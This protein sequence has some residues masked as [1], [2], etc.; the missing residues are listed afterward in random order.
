MLNKFSGKWLALDG[1]DAVGKSTQVRLVQK[2]LLDAG[3]DSL[4][5]PEFSD[6][7]VGQTIQS[8][9]ERQRFYALH[10]TKS[11]PYADTYALL[12]DMAF[13][14]ES[15]GHQ[16]LQ[17]GGVVL[18]DRGLLSLIGYQAKRVEDYSLIQRNDAV[19]RITT[20]ATNSISHLHVPDLHILLVLNEEEMQ[21]R[22]VG[23]GETPLSNEDLDFMKK[24]RTIMESLSTKIPS[25]IL[26]T[27]EMTKEEATEEIIRLA[28]EHIHS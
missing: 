3:M 6:S 5:L 14:I 2:K 17:D 19:D 9:I 15:S 8:I 25:V 23:R 28:G 4:V 26:D 27:S 24:V 21:R 1:T 7:P 20:I 16:T 18:S 11:T 12:S 22:I 10:A 13:H